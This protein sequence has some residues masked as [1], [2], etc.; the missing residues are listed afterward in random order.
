[1]Q[2][3]TTEPRKLGEHG[4]PSYRWS[5]NFVSSICAAGERETPRFEVVIF[6]EQFMNISFS[7][8]SDELLNAH[9][10]KEPR[11]WKSAVLQC[12]HFYFSV[13]LIFL[14]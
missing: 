11:V 14:L 10:P 1:M 7:A 12:G 3:G 13:C 8:I 9:S 6:F 5:K 2:I 4:E